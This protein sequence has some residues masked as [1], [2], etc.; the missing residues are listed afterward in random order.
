[1]EML[2][3]HDLLLSLIEKRKSEEIQTTLEEEKP[4]E[5]ILRALLQKAPT[6]AN[7]FLKGQRAVNPLKS[8][9][10]KTTE[11]EF[12]GK[13]H[14]TFFKFKDKPY[15]QELQRDCHINL[16]CRATFE[17][18]VENDYFSRSIDRGEFA[19][20]LVSNGKRFKVSDF[21][22]PNLLDGKATLNIQLPANCDV[23]DVLHLETA[24]SDPTLLE[25]FKNGLVLTIK[26]PAIPQQRPCVPVGPRPPSNGT[27]GEGK[28]AP[29]GIAMPK[30][31][32]VDEAHWNSQDPPFDR[33]TALRI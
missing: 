6:L 5:D 15:G 18:D 12:E 24:V 9:Q 31:T 8:I 16:R 26:P 1:M 25:P 4:L 3:Q 22:G 10:D 13:K 14:P 17:T 30:I 7:L 21:I 23:G 33:F 27:P 29:A 20:H 2:R 19:L 32:P 28:D 11:K